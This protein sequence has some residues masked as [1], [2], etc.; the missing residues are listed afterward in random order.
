MK[1]EYEKLSITVKINN[2]NYG[3]LHYYKG[4]F[5]NAVKELDVFVKKHAP[6]EYDND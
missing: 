6:M 2:Q 5:R 4:Q 3:T 1:R